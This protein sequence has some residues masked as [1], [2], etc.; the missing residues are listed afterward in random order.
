MAAPE[1]IDHWKV[2][3]GAELANS[4]LFLSQLCRLLGVDEPDASGDDESRNKYVFEKAVKFNNGDG[5]T[6]DGRVDLYRKGCFVLES[7][8]GVDRKSA[9]QAEAL[10]T[11]TR[12]NRFRSGTALRGTP[13]WELAM[14]A[15]RQQARRYAEAIP[16][17]WP[18][19]LIVADIG[20][21]FD[22]YADFTQSGKNYVPF[23]DPRSYRIS[24][25]D[26]VNDATCELLRT[27]WC[28]P[29]SLDPSRRTARVTRELANRLA[30]LAKSLEGKHSPELV[31]QFLMRCLF[32]MFAEDVQ[33]GGF[34][35]GDFTRFLQ[36]RRGKLDTFV[37]MLQQLWQ[38]MDTG[39]FSVVLEANLKRFNGGLFEGHTAVAVNEDQLELLIEAS[40]AGWNEV[41]PAIFGTLLE[42]ALDPVERH[43]LG[44]HYTPRAYVERLV[45]PTI[46]EPLREQWDTTYAAAVSQYNAGKGA[47]AIKTVRRF[48]EQLCETRVLDPACG[49]G[50]FLYVAL[51]LMKRLEGEVLK[52]LRDFGDHQQVLLTIDPHQFLGIDINDRAVALADLVLWIGYLQWHLRTR[53]VEDVREPIIKKFRNIECRDAVLAWDDIEPV[54]DEHGNPVTRW[55]G[56]TT[57]KHPVTGQE[58]PDETARVQELRYINPRKTEWPKAD[59][60]VGNPPYLGARRNRL[61]LGDGYLTALRKV[62]DVVPD[63]VD[64]VMYWWHRAAELLQ[65]NRASRFG[66]ITTKSI[67]QSFAQRLLT[68]HLSQ[69]APLSFRFAIPN[70]PWIDAADGADV[71]VALT[72]CDS[73]N[74]TGVLTNVTQEKPAS[75][76]ECTIDVE[77]SVGP[78]LPSLRIGAFLSACEPL[79][80]NDGVSCVG[81]QLT[82][83]GFTLSD[84]ALR[85]FES[86]DPTVVSVI[87]PLLSARDIAQT[88]RGLFAIDLF[89]CEID[90]VRERL[91]AI[92]QW[93]YDRVKP[94]RDQNNRA[95]V[96]D[97]WWLHGECRSTFRPAL[98]GLKRL[99]VT[100]LTAKFRYF[101]FEPS[102]TVCD[103][104]T[105]MIAMDDPYILGVMSSRTHLAW[106][107]VAGGRLGVGN[108]PR[109]V[110]TKCFD[111]FPFPSTDASTEEWIRNLGEQ[112]DA[113]RKRQQELYPDLTMTGM[114]NVLE[115]L[116]AGGELTKKEKAIHE[117][118]LVSVLKQ[119]HDDLD[120]AV[121]DAYGWPHKLEDEEILQRLVDL[122]HERAA[123]EQRGIIRWLRPEFQNPSG[124]KATQTKLD[125]GETESKPTKTTPV[126]RKKQAWPSSLP[127]QFTAVHA[128]I[129]EHAAPATPADMAKYFTRAKKATVEE[130]LDTLVA[131]GQVRQ[132]EDGLYVA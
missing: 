85:R 99:I 60:I 1:F 77:T 119:I 18:P 106:A 45:M 114:Y 101:L 66:L 53:G 105:V 73:S 74:S 49:S 31:A 58:V 70:H 88:R 76:G 68:H 23:P 27:I 3:G 121:F 8:Q 19:F 65:D 13:G 95:A 123:E 89:G 11:T 122:N 84:D 91:P 82:G 104:T 4:Q 50:N 47:E 109:Y 78:I 94:E 26:L 44:A 48:H 92:Y 37:P 24:L 81:Y 69:D 5:T 108:D 10:A 29:L 62:Y 86:D 90:D 126:K 17:E 52:T 67:S 124:K 83:K 110:K 34:K 35:K 80:A 112:L 97:K 127:G 2:S 103:S 117:K 7:K 20:H 111:P 55:D 40:E 87:H 116:R 132:T 6:S 125:I 107:V 59:Y 79:K 100:P 64:Y 46:M 56:R 72:V 12:A 36:S 38:E 54:F 51:E 130:I 28:D 75:D 43:K 129:T 33:L 115:K 131:V 39:G 16:D 32:T 63:N 41:E 9:E 25:A 128:A 71:R 118:G 15:A 98:I 61:A 96:R 42:R 120:A 102:D 93:I 57:K 22:L 21:C 30:K 14:T 113:H